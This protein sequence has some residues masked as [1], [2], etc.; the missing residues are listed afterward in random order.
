MRIQVSRMRA[1]PRTA[2]A[3]LL[4]ALI[5]AC[6]TE[7]P[8]GLRPDVDVG[9][10][11][12]ALPRAEI[13]PQ[14]AEINPQMEQVAPP[15]EQASPQIEQAPPRADFEAPQIDEVAP[16]EPIEVAY[17]RLDDP[18]EPIEPPAVM[19]SA[20]EACRR[21]LKRLGV[22]FQDIDPIHESAT[23][24]IDWPVKVSAIGNVQ[25]KPAATLSCQMAASFARWTRKEL[26]PTARWRYMSGVRTIHQ[27]SSY[28]CRNI[29]GSR[30]TPSQHSI[31]NALDVMRI[32]LNNGKDIDV[33][34]PGWFA[35]RQ[36][37]FLNTVRKDG[38]HYFNT[39]LGP[40]YNADHADHFH[41]DIMPRKNGYVACK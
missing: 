29:R 6:S 31:G 5:T 4:A 14:V 41:F 15:I 11:T 20:E 26:V 2:T 12:A 22:R 19:S 27:G 24:H 10:S 33:R 3:F 39:V 13:A 30:G 28:S 38:C 18:V 21:D 32:E 36:K 35:F 17:P 7:N 16:E 40:G 1:L 9:T 25:M 8:L 37:A 23:C 34:K